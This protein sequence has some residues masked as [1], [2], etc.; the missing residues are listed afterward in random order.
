MKKNKD[1]LSA[2]E[3]QVLQLS[4]KGMTRTEISKALNISHHTV[5]YHIRNSLKKLNATNITSAVVMAISGG[6][7][8]LPE[9]I[10]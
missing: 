10:E 1:Q 4:A 9:S 6:L 2:K 5:D 7:L 8:K 3:K